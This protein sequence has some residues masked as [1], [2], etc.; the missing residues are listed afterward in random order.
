MSMY[1]S[2]PS[3]PRDT[4]NSGCSRIESWSTSKTHPVIRSTTPLYMPEGD[5]AGSCVTPS[6]CE[7]AFDMCGPNQEDGASRTVETFSRVSSTSIPKPSLATICN[8]S[9]PVV[10]LIGNVIIASQVVP[11]SLDPIGPTV[12]EVSV[13]VHVEQMTVQPISTDSTRSSSDARTVHRN[14]SPRAYSS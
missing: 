12:H 1:I 6:H 11:L 5:V 2:S 4:R 8:A 3:W 13:I 14:E 9:S 10:M 7:S